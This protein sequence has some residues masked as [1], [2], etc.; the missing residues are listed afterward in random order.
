MKAEP[1]PLILNLLLGA[2]GRRLAAREAVAACALFGI[3][4]NSVRVTLARLSAAGLVE[5]VDRGEYRLG[6]GA[7]SL[8]DDVST[9]RDAERRVRD[10]NGDWLAAHVGDLGRSDRAVLRARARALE[11]LGLRELDR[12]LYLRPDNLAGGVAAVR[13]RLLALGLEPEAA[14]FVA[15]GFDAA[16]ERRAVAL[17]DGR[18]LTRAYR[19]THGRLDAWLARADSLALDTAA[20]ESFLLGND[21]IRQLVFDPLLP[22][23][24]VDVDARRAFADAVARFDAAGHA[25]WNRFLRDGVPA[26]ASARA[27]P[28]PDR[29]RS[30]RGAA[31]SSPTAIQET[32][33]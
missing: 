18:A 7:A 5:A 13:A 14:V 6:P 23:P 1:R 19:D 27:R 20:R 8:A 9:W 28:A 10:W 4:E 2:A 32:P 30:A 16:R 29:Q 22:A 24:L 12:G 21:A 33:T 31:R 15:R 3:R 11:L 25:I 17:W 26:R